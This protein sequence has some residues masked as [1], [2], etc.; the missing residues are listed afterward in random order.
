MKI[1]VNTRLLINQ[2][3]EGIQWFT[4]ET[5]RRITQAHPEHSFYFIFDR[6]YQ[7]EF[8]FSKNVIPLI[9]SPQARHPFLFYVWFHCRI[10]K[11]LKKHKIDIFVSP[12]GFLPLKSSI[13]TLAVIHDI[14][15]EHQTKGIPF[16]VAHYYKHYFPKYARLATKIATVSEFSK[17]D[18]VKKYSI[19]PQKI[20][21][22]HNGIN[23]SFVPISEMEKE[24]VRAAYS[25]GKPFFVFVGSL[26]PRKNLCNLLKAFDQYKKTDTSQ[27]Q[28][29]VVGAT[30]FKTKEIFR[31]HKTM[32]YSNEVHLCGH[33]YANE[34]HRVLSSAKALAYVSHFEGFGIP[35]VEAFACDTPVITS[36]TSSMPEV[37]GE[38]AL[39][40]DPNSVEE[41]ADALKKMDN[42]TVRAHFIS[43][44]RIQKTKFS[45]SKTALLLWDNMEALLSKMEQKQ[46]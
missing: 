6:P 8:I 32:A 36:N 33:L 29:L 2:K 13:P 28:L 34:L 40:V 18:I 39:Y 38:A 5:L 4:F 46:K 11:L 3:M 23:E 37:A 21:V 7:A 20:S 30:L 9:L 43:L 1:A 14:N 44:G 41:I 22:V 42:E 12:D 15:F 16:L 19:D 35:I 45:W 27:T 26:H 10:P 24:V 17:S 31:T 25:N